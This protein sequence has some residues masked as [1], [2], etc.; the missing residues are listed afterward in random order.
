MSTESHE[1]YRRHQEHKLP[2]NRSFAWVMTVGFLVMGL[3]PLK[4][5]GDIRIWALVISGMFLG[6]GLLAP[7]LLTPLNRAW[8]G[9]A[10]LLSRVVNPVIMAVLFYGVFTPMGWLMKL[11]GMDVLG[12]TR[13]PATASY[14]I[15]R[16][17]KE[18]G[19]MKNQF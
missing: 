4:K 15:D 6:V 10:L 12:A 14:W 16:H 9:L 5:G 7:A 2:S 8:M 18:P 3:W 1:D 11:M 17:G 19:S 13:D